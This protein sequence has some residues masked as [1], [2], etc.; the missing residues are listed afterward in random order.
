MMQ[1]QSSGPHSQEM[2]D[3]YA[4]SLTHIPAGQSK[5]IP[6]KAAK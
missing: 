6:L 1:K 2:S 5:R 3:P 4:M